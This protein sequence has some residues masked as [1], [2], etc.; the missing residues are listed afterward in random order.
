M[1]ELLLKSIKDPQ[2]QEESKV[3][4]KNLAISLIK[5][6]RIIEEVIK[7]M[8]KCLQDPEVKLESRFLIEW[9]LT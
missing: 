4:G 7:L 3:F 1:L 5:D 6:D 2:F 9:I 8:V